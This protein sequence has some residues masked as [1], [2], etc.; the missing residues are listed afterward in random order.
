MPLRLRLGLFFA[1]LLVIVVG[2]SFNDYLVG[3]DAVVDA[4]LSCIV[5]VVGSAL[6]LQFSLTLAIFVVLEVV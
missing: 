4:L 5:D 3:V 2:V 1:K 6:M